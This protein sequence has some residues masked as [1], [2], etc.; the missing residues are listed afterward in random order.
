[1]TEF[2]QS[3]GATVQNLWSCKTYFWLLAT[4]RT[5][6]VQSVQFPQ[7][8]SPC[9]CNVTYEV[10][11]LINS[12]S[13]NPTKWLNTLKKPYCFSVFDHFVGLAL[14]G[15]RNFFWKLI[16]TLGPKTLLLYVSYVLLFTWNAFCLNL[17]LHLPPRHIENPVKDLRWSFCK[18]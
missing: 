15:L 8:T 3:L 13:A 16:K 2:S 9:N 10:C 14:K 11:Y 1:M 18:K 7:G 17:S 5:V 4:E 6:S 12:L